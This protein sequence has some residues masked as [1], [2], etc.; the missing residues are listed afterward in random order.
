MDIYLV[1]H[2]SIEV[3]KGICYG[4]S[5]VDV[6][7]SFTAEAALVKERL[8][9]IIRGGVSFS[10]VYCSPL[11]R[12]R[13]LAQF[14]GYSSPLIE[15]RVLEINFGEWEMKPFSE[16]KDPRLLEWYDDYLNVR[17]TGGESFRDQYN[18]VSCFLK[19]LKDKGKD[20]T[21]IFTH[22]GVLICA[23]IFAGL[24]SAEEAFGYLDDYGTVIKVTI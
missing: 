10:E 14:C 4:Q 1:R 18:R 8:E 6:K 7:E 9:E 24:I 17:A 19:E 5:D 3:G 20:N 2:T 11:Q 16:I 21:L 12:C 23:K 22:G 13:K 15:E